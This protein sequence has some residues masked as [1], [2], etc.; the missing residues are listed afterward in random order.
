M[1]EEGE[2][3]SELILF[4]YSVIKPHIG[5]VNLIFFFNKKGKHSELGLWSRSTPCISEELLC[6][7]Q[8]TCRVT[9]HLHGEGLKQW[10]ANPRSLWVAWV[11]D[12]MVLPGFVEL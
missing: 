5:H 7:K 10:L 11:A 1:G 2:E 8:A 9:R 4:E 12:L 6:N 3:N